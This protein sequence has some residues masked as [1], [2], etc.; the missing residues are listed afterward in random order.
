MK[1]KKAVLI[2]ALI[3]V[4]ALAALAMGSMRQKPEDNASYC[5]D[6]YSEIYKNQ[7]RLIFGEDYVIGEK[8]TIV[9]EGEDC[10]CG[11]HTNDF[12][13]D[14]WKISYQDQN[15]QTYEQTLENKSSL[16]AQQISWLASQLEQYYTQKYLVDFFEEGTFE[17]L[18]V[19]GK[20]GRTYC[21]ISI[22]SPV[23]SYTSDKKEE[24]ER[25]REAGKGYKEQLLKQLQKE[26]NMLR[27]REVDYENIFNC[28]PV[29]VRFYLSI[30]DEALSGA[31]K[32]NFEEAVRERV[33]EMI[34]AIKQETGDTCNLRIQVDSANGHCDL[35]D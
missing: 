16:E 32:E 23:F 24:F 9:I 11:Y 1:R 26:K 22:G 20:H 31:E 7:L 6:D 34:Q 19:G 21:S 33:M 14:E 4:A 10:D 2:L 27:L 28:F 29:E 30:D 35:Y 13:Y 15:G 18:S 3:L 5:T 17:D 12:E 8:E 25:I